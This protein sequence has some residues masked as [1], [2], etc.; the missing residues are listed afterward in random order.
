[1]NAPALEVR[2]LRTVLETRNGTLPAV[3]GLD[4]SVAVGETLALVGESGCGKSMTALSI[5][6][7][8]PS[9]PARTIAGTVMVAGQDLLALSEREMRRLRGRSIS[10][11]FQDPMG[12]LN[13]V[14]TVHAQ[15]LEVVQAHTPLRRDAA[16]RRLVELLTL[17]GIP[18][19]VSRLHEFPHRLS[20]GMSQRVMIAMAIACEPSV[21]LAD[22]PTTALDVTVQA[23]VL[24]VL[25]EIQ[26]RNGMAIVLITH[27]L[28]VVAE[29]A[30]RVAVMY[31]G[32]KVEEAAVIPLFDAPLHPYTRGL[33]GATPVRGAARLQ[34]IPGQVPALSADAT[35]CLYAP[36]C[37]LV[38]PQCRVKRPALTAPAPGRLV[39][40][41]ATGVPVAT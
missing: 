39:A 18:D 16:E 26:R 32:H 25:R 24:R 27:D 23:Q 4:L 38:M 11:I 8:L 12:S 35:G 3:A 7:L 17:V 13:P 14:A 10:M 36:R 5:M 30:D 29:T 40:C 19:P 9:P 28:G 2:G 22:E 20:G 6:R 41:F 15:L 33:L 31:A 37:P 21:L 1:M 34:E